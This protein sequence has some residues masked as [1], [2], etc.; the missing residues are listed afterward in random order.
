MRIPSWLS[1]RNIG[2]YAAP[3][4]IVMMLAI[5][6]LPL[7]AFALDILFSF[8]IAL[9]IIVLLTSLIVSAVRKSRR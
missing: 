3:L 6:V 1:S 7:P 5:M 8:N 2:T 9:S 4:I